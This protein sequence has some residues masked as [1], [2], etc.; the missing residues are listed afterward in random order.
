MMK[1][2]TTRVLLALALAVAG[3]GERG[4]EDAVA[5]ADT[6]AARGEDAA[7]APAAGA[8][9]AG[10]TEVTLAPVG[11]SGVSGGATLSEQGERVQVTVRLSGLRPNGTHA[12]HVH[13]G[14]CDSPGAVVAPLLD[15]SADAS[16]SGTS[17]SLVAA[18]VSTVMDG[19]H[20]VVYHEA[21]ES[22]GAPAVCGAIP[23][24]RM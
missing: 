3:C 9:D 16:G 21:G 15:V 23:A 19:R 7:A 17:T 4:E 18:P 12:G 8:A 6:T 22:P 10:T 13:E 20:V 11:G 1:Q 14:T 5:G 2:P 24:R